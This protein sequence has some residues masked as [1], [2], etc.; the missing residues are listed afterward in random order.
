MG[1]K[2]SE[3][4]KTSIPQLLYHI[5]A[6][7]SSLPLSASLPPTFGALLC[8]SLNSLFFLCLSLPLCLFGYTPPS[9]NHTLSS[10]LSLSSSFT[11]SLSLL[12][13]VSPSLSVYVTLD[14]CESIRRQITPCSQ[15]GENGNSIKLSVGLRLFLMHTHIHARRARAC[16]HA[17]TRTHIFQ[18][19]DLPIS[20]VPQISTGKTICSYC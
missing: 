12:I 3:C 14:G 8:H 13:A 11:F 1:L 18:R 5:I 16:A 20:R 2:A 4:R 15:K 9:I 19:T 17:H 10:Y 7:Y 6:F